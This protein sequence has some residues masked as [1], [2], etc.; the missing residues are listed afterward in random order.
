[1]SEQRFCDEL[2]ERNLLL[3]ALYKEVYQLRAE[4]E[5]ANRLHIPKVID[6]LVRTRDVLRRSAS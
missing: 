1:V 5:R 3:S 2:I 4:I 6:A